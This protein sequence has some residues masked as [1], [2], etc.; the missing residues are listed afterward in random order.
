MIH[1]KIEK[2]GQNRIE[3]VNPS[4]IFPSDRSLVDL[5]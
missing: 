2:E 5:I 3:L 1:C 4:L